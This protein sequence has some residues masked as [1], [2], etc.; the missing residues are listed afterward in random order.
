MPAQSVAVQPLSNGEVVYLAGFDH[1]SRLRVYDGRITSIIW[2]D[3]RTKSISHD[4]GTSMSVNGNSGGPIWNA[5]GQIVSNLWGATQGDTFAVSNRELVS[6]IREVSAKHPEHA[7][8]LPQLVDPTGQRFPIM[9]GGA[10]CQTCPQPIVTRPIMPSPTQGPPGRDGADGAQGPMGSAGGIGQTGPQGPPGQDA[11]VDIDAITAAVLAKLPP[12]YP[13][14]IDAEGNV[15]DEI[16]GGVRLG[17]TLP[18]RIKVL[19]S[20]GSN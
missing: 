4:V 13:M 10:V 1:G 14:W 7:A 2:S 8:T 15:I 5:N 17:Q 3:G 11:I 19:Q 9:G 20:A 16:P 6:F 18:L 12:I